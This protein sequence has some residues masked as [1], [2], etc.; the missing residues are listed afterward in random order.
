MTQVSQSTIDFIAD[1][2]GFTPTA[3]KDGNHYSIGYG[4]YATA[5]EVASGAAI[6]QADAKERMR[7]EAQKAQDYVDSTFHPAGGLNANQNTSLVSMMYNVGSAGPT[8]I[9]AVNNGTT[10]Q[11]QAAMNLYHGAENPADAAGVTNRRNV[12]VANYGAPVPPGNVGGPGAGATSTAVAGGTPLAPTNNGEQV[13]SG[14]G[15][16]RYAGTAAP[17]GPYG[18]DQ[19]VNAITSGGSAE[20]IK[21][22]GA[23]VSAQVSALPLLSQLG[24]LSQINGYIK[25]LPQT[26]PGA[27]Q[28]LQ[29]ALHSNPELLNDPA[30]KPLL[31]AITAAIGTPVNP[32]ALPNLNP[33]RQNGNALSA[34]AS[35]NPN[36][37]RGLEGPNYTG[38]TAGPPAQS[39]PALVAGGAPLNAAPP[40]SAYAASPG[41]VA[42]QNALNSMARPQSAWNPRT[43]AQLQQGANQVDALAGTSGSRNAVNALSAASLANGGANISG[44]AG[45]GAGGLT[46]WGALNPNQQRGLE[47]YSST[48][49]AYS[50]AQT[51]WRPG[52]T[53]TPPNPQVR[54]SWSSAPSSWP[55]PM[56]NLPPSQ[57]NQSPSSNSGYAYT[58]APATSA[59]D[60]YAMGATS[61]PAARTADSGL[62]TSAPQY[63]TAPADTSTTNNPSAYSTPSYPAY[64]PTVTSA[65]DRLAQT[66][67]SYGT[68]TADSGL[69]S[70]PRQYW[71]PPAPSAPSAPYD[72]YAYD[73]LANASAY[74]TMLPRPSANALSAASASGGNAGSGYT[75]TPQ[76]SSYQ[77]ASTSLPE[78]TG[79]S[80]SSGQGMGSI[81]GD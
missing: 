21:A 19:F 81:Y 76:Q 31:P 28:Y 65:A 57:G 61:Y 80:G 54:E 10:A 42:L 27:V 77:P 43:L 37:L 66:G 72:Q 1:R 25:A 2:E 41:D 48:D 47:G 44:G 70:T 49:E 73:P 63:W 64:N 32:V 14:G 23:A 69:D 6:S 36:Q 59:A 20:A 38:P 26:A 4:T 16:T 34:L 33:F 75:Q 58:P 17:Q 62:S 52:Q 13:L 35:L 18:F 40:A 11:A 22:A 29:N 5:A 39:A 53:A 8:L 46:S 51:M 3:Y 67:P 79:W 74:N 78:L 7:A 15:T 50:G 9:N 60:R 12:E 45:S 56:P 68:R 24:A 55:T 71:T 30:L